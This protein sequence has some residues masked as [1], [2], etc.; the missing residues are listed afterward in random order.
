M[1]KH[2]GDCKHD[3]AQCIAHEQA[4]GRGLMHICPNTR[5][6]APKQISRVEQQKQQWRKKIPCTSGEVMCK[7]AQLHHATWSGTEKLPC[8]ALLQP[9]ALGSS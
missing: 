3:A 9:V 4:C 2:Q 6:Q 7:H 8:I 1:A 5:E